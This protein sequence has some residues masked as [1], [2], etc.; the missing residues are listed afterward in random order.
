MNCDIL[1]YIIKG[2]QETVTCL[3]KQ[4]EF[5]PVLEIQDLQSGPGA[6]QSPGK[7]VI[8][9]RVLGGSSQLGNL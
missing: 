1:L 4:Q 6:C 8:E 5:R 7:D 2:D 3:N 9:H